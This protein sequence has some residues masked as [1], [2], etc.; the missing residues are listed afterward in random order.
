MINII[1][2]KILAICLILISVN[3]F[4][5]NFKQYNIF[6]IPDKSATT[7][8]NNFNNLANNSGL[9]KKYKIIPFSKNHPTHLSLYITSFKSQYLVNIIDLIKNIAESTEQFDI[10]TNQITVGKSG[11]VMLDVDNS[12][13]LQNLSDINITKLSKYRDKDYSM[14]SWVRYYP[15]KEIS[16]KKYGTPNAFIQFDPHFSILVTILKKNNTKQDF[17]N[18]FSKAIQEFNSTPKKIKI[19]GI[20]LGE[21]DNYGQ[22]TKTIKKYIFKTNKRKKNEK[23]TF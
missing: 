15:E 3:V 5:N 23:Y 4:A 21:V 12:K 8:I 18:D 9:Y 11:F 14:P 6:L 13:T 16:F 1:F 10:T 20:G 17:V 7:Y 22:V 19:I 2:P